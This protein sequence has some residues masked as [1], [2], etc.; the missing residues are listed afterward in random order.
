M[1]SD[2]GIIWHRDQDFRRGIQKYG[3]HSGVESG[4]GGNVRGS[5]TTSGFHHVAL[6]CRNMKETVK[7]YEE[8]L[9]MKLRAIFP[10]HGVPGA[11]HCFIE[12]GN[13]SEISFVE[14]SETV[15]G[16]P[17]VSFPVNSGSTSPVGSHHH[18]AYKA[19]S[20]AQL[21]RLRDQV[22]KTGVMVSPVLSHEFVHSFYFT[23][24]NGFQLEVSCTVRGYQGKEF[25]TDLLERGL[26][27]EEHTWESV[28]MVKEAREY[29]QKNL[30]AEEAEKMLNKK[31]S[32]L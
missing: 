19:D 3:S 12:A 28:D 31:K 32:K 16:V 7:F 11:K 6:V 27:P 18:M 24:P 5:T 10:M 1:A 21:Y 22:K 9:G 14:F 15:E 8:G 23:D 30:P 26:T 29:A 20:L 4:T 17:G 25:Q 13:G 2:E